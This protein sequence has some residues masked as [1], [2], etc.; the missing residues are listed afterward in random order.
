MS[1]EGPAGG[2]PGNPGAEG[3]HLHVTDEAYPCPGGQGVGLE[4]HLGSPACE[5]SVG[6]TGGRWLQCIA[7]QVPC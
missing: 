3:G 4:L 5:S 2:E 6:D 1:R 7:T